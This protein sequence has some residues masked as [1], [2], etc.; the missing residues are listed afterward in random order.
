MRKRLMPPDGGLK[1]P[2]R[3]FEDTFSVWDCI[4]DYIAKR[5]ACDKK[6]AFGAANCSCA[7]SP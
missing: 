4:N 5:E 2:V 7:G 1:E 3:R 6:C